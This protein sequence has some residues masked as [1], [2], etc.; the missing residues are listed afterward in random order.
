MCLSK[1]RIVCRAMDIKGYP[2]E[3]TSQ[4]L[5]APVEC[6]NK[7]CKEGLITYKTY[8]C[9]KGDTFPLAVVIIVPLSLG[10]IIAFVIFRSGICKSTRRSARRNE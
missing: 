10:I 1:K 2:M 3:E 7:E 6:F 9:T 4:F 8:D 5:C